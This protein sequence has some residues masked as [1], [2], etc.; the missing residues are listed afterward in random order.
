MVDG[1]YVNV[2]VGDPTGGALYFLE[3]GSDTTTGRCIYRSAG[4][5]VQFYGGSAGFVFKSAGDT[6]LVTITNG[7]QTTIKSSDSTPRV[8][9][10]GDP[11]HPFGAN[12]QF[13]KNNGDATW[14]LGASVANGDVHDFGLFDQQPGGGMRLNVEGATGNLAIGAGRRC[15]G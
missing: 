9:D 3:A 2:R 14:K 12:I 1:N 13:R 6:T 8:L 15:T 4:D 11:A 5:A 10:A 7:G